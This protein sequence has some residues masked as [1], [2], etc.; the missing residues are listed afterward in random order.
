MSHVQDNT[1]FVRQCIA[2]R[3][4]TGNRNPLEGGLIIAAAEKDT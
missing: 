1:A 4:V 2:V 3:L